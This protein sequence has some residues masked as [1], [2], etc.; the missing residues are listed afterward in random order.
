M[1][2]ETINGK[3]S[4]APRDTVAVTMQV[5]HIKFKMSHTYLEILQ[6]LLIFIAMKD[7]RKYILSSCLLLPTQLTM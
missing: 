5:I 1:C 4:P 2:Q 7:R 3:L 6:N